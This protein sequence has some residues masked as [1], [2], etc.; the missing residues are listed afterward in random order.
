MSGHVKSFENFLNNEFANACYEDLTENIRFVP[1][2]YAKMTKMQCAERPLG[3]V[4]DGEFLRDHETQATKKSQHVFRLFEEQ[5]FISFVSEIVGEPITFIRPATPYKFTYGNYLCLHDDMSH[6]YHAYEVVL[7]LTKN[8]KKSYGG[9]SIGGH[10][11]R[12]EDA[13]TPK[14]LPF[15]M[16][17]IVLDTGKPHY[18]AIPEFNKLTVLKLDENLCHGTS[19][20]RVNKQRIVVACIYTNMLEKKITTKWL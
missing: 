12:R 11:L 14:G 16:Q 6:P 4:Y 10:V 3:S 7:N 1:H 13:Y 15:Q 2:V 5:K 18:C 9:Y 17:R 20:I 8:W 19:T